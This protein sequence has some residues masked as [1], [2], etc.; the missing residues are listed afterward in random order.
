MFFCCVSWLVVNKQLLING[1][2]TLK[3][4]YNVKYSFSFIIVVG[5]PLNLY[6]NPNLDK[7]E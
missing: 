2:F 1:F 7:A 3:D 5:E 4:F 6:Y